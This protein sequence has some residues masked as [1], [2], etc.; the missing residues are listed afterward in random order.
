MAAFLHAAALV[1]ADGIPARTF[2]PYAKR[3]LD[4][5]DGTFDG[6]AADVDRGAHDGSEDNLIM[7][8]A[9]LDH[10]V[11]TSRSRDL[12][13]DLPAA[14]QA[15]AQDAVTAG[16]GADSFSR[17]VDVIRRPHRAEPA[18]AA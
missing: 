3:M 6:L 9:F 2:L 8:V 10:I 7:E 16:H 14:V 17:V 12:D 4:L 1:G 15:L 11:T 18:D 5:L 13:T